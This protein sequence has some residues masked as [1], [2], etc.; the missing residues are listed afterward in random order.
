M[1]SLETNRML[2]T[3]GVALHFL[4]G[5]I[6]MSVASA[7]VNYDPAVER[8]W[9]MFED[10]LTFLVVCIIAGISLI[11]MSVVGLFGVRSRDTPTLLC[12]Y[13]STFLL[14]ILQLAYAGVIFENT[15]HTTVEGLVPTF[16]EEWV[17]MATA[18]QTASDSWETQSSQAFLTYMQDKG[19][20]CGFDNAAAAE[21][22]PPGL[23]CTDS[24]ACQETFVAEFKAAVET[25]C[26]VIFVF[27]SLELVTLFV[28][29][30]L[31]CR[32]K[33][34]PGYRKPKSA[35]GNQVKV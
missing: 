9:F 4:G 34:A 5:L 33:N 28:L 7:A 27:A 12:F 10:G 3:G 13:A 19:S 25:K 8:I 18:S 14:D 23:K 1:P 2:V 35:I 21:Q 20:C 6:L 29:W 15:Q 32:Y 31:T 17:K 24:T 11:G 22:N 16:K 30:G 26:V